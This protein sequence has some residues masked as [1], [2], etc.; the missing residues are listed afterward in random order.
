MA[1]KKTDNAALPGMGEGDQNTMHQE[2]EEQ[3][4]LEPV[5]DDAA[6]TP[7]NAD[8]DGA[9]FDM[10]FAG[11]SD[12][13]A[14][15][16][17]DLSAADADDPV[18]DVGDNI[19]NDGDFG[20]D[21][22]PGEPEETP[23]ASA[24]LG[25]D[26]AGWPP[27]DDGG[28]LGDDPLSV[29]LDVERRLEAELAA[30][31]AEAGTDA[32]GETGPDAAGSD[33][34]DDT[35]NGAKGK[36]SKTAT[37]RKKA[38]TPPDPPPEDSG[39]SEDGDGDALLHAT[40]EEEEA[41]DYG[42]PL[43]DAAEDPPPEESTPAPTDGSSRQAGQ[44]RRDTDDVQESSEAP[45]GRTGRARSSAGA[46][47]FYQ[48][49]FNRLDRDLTDE[50]RREWNEIYASFRSQS[51]LTGVVAGVDQNELPVRGE[52][53]KT[54]MRVINSLV[55]ISY[56]V[57]VL[58]PESAVWMRGEERGAFL[59]RGMI[60]AQVDY[61]ITNVDREGEVALGSRTLALVKRRRAFLSG[62]R[63]QAGDIVPCSVL[64]VG[65]RRCLVTCGGYDVPLRSPDMSYTSILDMRQMYRPGQELKARVM[66][67]KPGDK[68]KLSVKEAA[69][70]PFDGAERRHPVGSRRQAVITGKYGG[71]V[72]CTLQDG[73]LCMCLYSNSHYD[74]DFLLGD[75]VIVHIS[76]YNY[77]NKHVYGR[78][79]SKW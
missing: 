48:T 52:N 18:G 53:G 59:L 6:G 61:V 43:E 15:D 24:G 63:T 45:A 5:G 19:G 62:R 46:S 20:G 35:E 16:T 75:N 37:R 13:D 22:L 33:V 41:A 29:T 39:W 76:Q 38:E 67:H 49:N 1:K 10:A 2:P 17:G 4:S 51:I 31:E 25:L 70:N 72:F 47:S 26:D 54:E 27:D 11:G 36:K 60:G 30:L 8:S 40:A 71:G 32:G 79:V 69:P 74:S 77:E 66:E 44:R 58:I 73:T 21:D 12:S 3:T 65:P 64:V 34:P 50:E 23:L 78:I 56:R 14:A 42:L 28:F 68:L 57:K 55:V 7:A 9:A